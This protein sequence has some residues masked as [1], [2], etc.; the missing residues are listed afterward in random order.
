MSILIDQDSRVVIQG[1]TGGMGRFSSDD[2]L[3]YGTN[4]VA[5]VSPGRGG[6]SLNGIPIYDFVEDAVAET[7]ANVSLIYVPAASG[8]GAVHESTEVGVPLIVYP[9]D[10]IPRHD[11]LLMRQRVAQT[12]TKLIGPNTPGLIS[13]GRAKVGFMPSNCYQPGPLGV[14][15]KSGSLSYEVC[16][17]MTKAGLGQS[18]VVGV[19][20]D[21]IK[22]LTIE[23]ALWEFDEDPETDAILVLGEVGGREEYGALSYLTEGGRKPIIAFIVG[24]TAPPGKK[25]GHAGALVEGPDEGYHAKM[26]AFEELDLPVAR[27][28]GDIP[29]LI[30]GVLAGTK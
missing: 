19:G 8:V 15:S 10:G 6:T 1:I 21:P 3:K 22:G 26:A 23:E 29:D 13:P 18:T 25:M 5:G 24:E 4:V 7:S 16:L 2:L 20:G 14:V 30:K 9:G 11:A 27:S 28:L 12:A 17:R